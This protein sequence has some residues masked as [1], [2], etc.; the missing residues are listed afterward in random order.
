MDNKILFIKISSGHKGGKLN[1]FGQIF[2]LVMGQMKTLKKDANSENYVFQY[3]FN[4][5]QCD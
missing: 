3:I 2:F 4:N 5:E 1:M